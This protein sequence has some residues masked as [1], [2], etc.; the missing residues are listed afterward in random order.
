MK[1]AQWISLAAIALLAV[2]IAVLVFRN[3][4]PPFLPTDSDHVWQN[5]ET[6]NDCHGPDGIP[7]SRNHPVG[8]DCKRCHGT[9]R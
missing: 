8:Q 2:L 3:R 1:S 5:A 4:Q 6:C 7:K 9:G